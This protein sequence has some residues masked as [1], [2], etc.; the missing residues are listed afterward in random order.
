MTTPGTRANGSHNPWQQFSVQSGAVVRQNSQYLESSANTFVFK[1]LTTNNPISPLLPEDA[2]QLVVSPLQ[3]L[4]LD[5]EGIFN[6]A[7]GTTG[8]RVDLNISRNVAIVG[9]GGTDGTTG[10]SGADY[11]NSAIVLKASALNDL[12]AESIL[13]GGTR[14]VAANSVGSTNRRNETYIV[15]ATSSITVDNGDGTALQ[16]PEIILA[17]S[18]LIDLTPTAI[19]KAVGAVAG[20]STGDLNFV[21]DFGFIVPHFGNYGTVN[22]TAGPPTGAPGSLVRVS[23][24]AAVKFERFGA[25]NSSGNLIIEPGSQLIS[26]NAIL[27]EGDQSATLE[28]GALLQAPSIYASGY[29]VSLGAVPGSVSGLD[30]SS[31]IFESLQATRDLTLFS[32]TSIDFWGSVSLGG[33][34]LANL[35]LDAGQLSNRTGNSTFTVNAG[36]VTIQATDSY[37][38]GNGITSGSLVLNATRLPDGSGGVITIGEGAKYIDGFS[39]VGLTA[40][41]Q[42]ILTEA[43]TLS[44]PGSLAF[45][46]PQLTAMPNAYQQI[47]ATGAF[48]LNRLSSAAQ[49]PATDPSLNSLLSVAASTVTIGGLIQMQSGVVQLEATT[50]DVVLNSGGAIDVSGAAAQFYDQYRY[51]AGGQVDLV[52]DAGNVTLA[53]GTTINVSGFLGT[54]GIAGGGDAGTISVTAGARAASPAIGFFTSQ[55]QLLGSAA[56]GNLSGSFVLN[57]GSIA[58]FTGLNAQL[59]AGGFAQSRNFRVRTG[60]VVLGGGATAHTFI[61]SADAGNIDVQGTIDASGSSGG[62]IFLAANGNVTLEPGSLLDAHATTVAVDAY[63]KPI[64]AENEA[65]VEI[66]TVSGTLNLAGGTINVSVPG[67]DAVTGQSFGGDVHLRASLI[68]N[69]EGDSIQVSSIGNII[70]ANSIDL[71][72]YQ[73]FTPNLGVIDKALVGTIQT[74][75]AGFSGTAPS[76]AGL[77]NLPVGIVHFRP[78]VEIDYNGD[79]AIEVTNDTDPN[80]SDVNGVGTAGW[81]FSTW[82]YNNEPGYLTVRAAGNLTVANSMSDG[83]TGVTSYSFVNNPANPKASYYS[84]QTTGPSWGFTLVSGAALGAAD[85]RQVQ[86]PSSLGRQGNFT[87][88]NFTLGL[89]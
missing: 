81:D 8:G 76:I 67:A 51:V 31:Q 87:S 44:V 30:F 68:A 80:Q 71:E 69:G 12:N 38:A 25:A 21:T 3:T 49:I 52:A 17:S 65:H 57:V 85:R 61:L 60:T 34:N 14:Q 63:G 83:F 1:D 18:N 24:G 50:G 54:S 32:Q 10:A 84:T 33:G 74:A 7:P 73:A 77:A 82:R 75:F 39:S 88:G 56:P 35:V 41:R 40:A 29:L 28:T 27:I 45:T 47:S 19:I 13:I 86:S 26:G 4:D 46:T 37:H 55:G 78:G 22:P 79:I 2:G 58:D 59:N 36:N 9:T 48:L 23:D 64:D 72:A 6:H 62:T 43:G 42:I 89:R 15:A 20:A 11:G 66:D 70:G 53:P 16:A 5:G